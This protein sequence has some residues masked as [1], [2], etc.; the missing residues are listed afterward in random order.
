M[1]YLLW[2]NLCLRQSCNPLY[3][4]VNSSSKRNTCFFCELFKTNELRPICF[5]PFS[6]IHWSK[7]GEKW[8]IAPVTTV[9]YVKYKGRQH[10]HDNLDS[11]QV[12]PLI[13]R[14]YKHNYRVICSKTSKREVQIKNIF[15]GRLTQIVIV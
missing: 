5:F 15:L 10:T 8:K 13:W 14:H 12:L 6:N 11:P 2:Q 4:G 7:T 9:T 1:S 3:H